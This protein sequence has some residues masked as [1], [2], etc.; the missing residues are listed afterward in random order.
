MKDVKEISL[1]KL[2]ADTSEY[3]EELRPAYRE[4]CRILLEYLSGKTGGSDKVKQAGNTVG[5]FGRILASEQN[6]TA[7]RMQALKMH[8]E[9]PKLPAPASKK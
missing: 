8:V 6:K 2:P 9:A 1:P 4:S 5:S 3:S 7:L